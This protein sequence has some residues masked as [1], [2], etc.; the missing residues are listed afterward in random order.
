MRLSAHI[1]WIRI[2]KRQPLGVEHSHYA[3]IRLPYADIAFFVF[4]GLR[5]DVIMWYNPVATS[6]HLNPS[7]VMTRTPT[8][9]YPCIHE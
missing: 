3:K 6:T 2:E 9:V 8:N 7:Y 5:A 4:I 1:L